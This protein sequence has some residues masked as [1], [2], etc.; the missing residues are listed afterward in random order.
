MD[1]VLRS[2][3][4]LRPRATASRQRQH[5]TRTNA[6]RRNAADS[7]LECS[8]QNEGR[9]GGKRDIRAPRATGM[10]SALRAEHSGREEQSRHGAPRPDLFWS[11]LAKP[12][13]MAGRAKKTPGS[14]HG[15]NL[16]FSSEKARS[17]WRS[18]GSRSGSSACTGDDGQSSAAAVMLRC[19]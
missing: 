4:V 19:C 2:E 16:V 8:R 3:H 17:V 1:P 13:E 14:A 12:T 11:L 10:L 18:R 9:E 6:C 5:T 15:W 7:P